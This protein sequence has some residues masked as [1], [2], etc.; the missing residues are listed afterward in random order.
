MLKFRDMHDVR[1]KIILR[2]NRRCMQYLYR[3]HF[4]AFRK[5]VK[6]MK[7]SVKKHISRFVHQLANPHKSKDNSSTI[8][9]YSIKKVFPPSWDRRDIVNRIV[10][11]CVLWNTKATVLR[12]FMR[13]SRM[14]SQRSHSKTVVAYCYRQKMINYLQWWAHVAALNKKCSR[15]LVKTIKQTFMKWRILTVKEWSRR[16]VLRSAWAKMR[17][18]YGFNLAARVWMRPVI[19]RMQSAIDV[20][21]RW[22]DECRDA[23]SVLTTLTCNRLLSHSFNMWLYWLRACDH[24]NLA[25]GWQVINQ[26][27]KRAFM[28]KI[29]KANAKMS[30]FLRYNIKNGRSRERRERCSAVEKQGDFHWSRVLYRKAV[31][32]FRYKINYR[33]WQSN[34]SS[35][36]LVQNNRHMT[37]RALRLLKELVRQKKQFNHVLCYSSLKFWQKRQKAVTAEQNMYALAEQFHNQR[38]QS[39]GVLQWKSV[40]VTNKINRSHLQVAEKYRAQSSVIFALTLFRAYTVS[41]GFTD[42]NREK[43]DDESNTSLRTNIM[44]TY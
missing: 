22:T 34:W 26:F 44:Y 8:L 20:W 43:E 1:K 21:R 4:R 30:V 11:H 42:D 35:K 37:R 36:G 24:F 27:K 23:E 33:E 17:V 28:G 6:F 10:R 19:S 29:A 7:E 2:A 31:A 14:A 38:L 5:R 12:W 25:L 41:D 9:F 18:M 39:R 40:S 3:K 32:L 16:S 15:Y 13:W